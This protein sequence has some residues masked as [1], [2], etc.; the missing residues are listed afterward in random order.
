MTRSLAAR[1]DM[2]TM[3]GY[4]RKHSRNGLDPIVIIIDAAAF[5]ARVLAAA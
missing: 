1:P 4:L 2:Q 3:L 5:V